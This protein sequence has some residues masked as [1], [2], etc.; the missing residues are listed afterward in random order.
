M[1]YEVTIRCGVQKGDPAAKIRCHSDPQ[2]R[3]PVPSVEKGTS[4]DAIVAVEARARG[5]DWVNRRR[6]SRPSI[7]ICPACVE[8]GHG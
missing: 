5:L 1:S 6:M 8:A 4:R 3:Q 7:W 2:A